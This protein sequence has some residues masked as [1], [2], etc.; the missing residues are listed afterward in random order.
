MFM[1]SSIV[2]NLLFCDDLVFDF[3]ICL[4]LSLPEIAL[5]FHLLFLLVS[6]F[7]QSVRCLV[8]SCVSCW[9]TFFIYDA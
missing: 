3:W 6:G 8:L 9:R 1:A 4:P 5:K 7:Y 2:S